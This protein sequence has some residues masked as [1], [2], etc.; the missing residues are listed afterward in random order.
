M[1]LR[2]RTLNGDILLTGKTAADIVT[3][4]RQSSGW[5]ANQTDERFMHDYADRVRL[6]SEFQTTVPTDNAENF[7]AA[8]VQY[9]D[10]LKD[11]TP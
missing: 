8:L 11:Q 4:L 7:V 6:A 1:T 2:Y 5:T 3:A 10:L 9:G